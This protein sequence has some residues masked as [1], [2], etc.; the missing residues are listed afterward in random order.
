MGWREMSS[1]SDLRS[2]I[3]NPIFYFPATAACRCGECPLAGSVSSHQKLER[4]FSAFCS[5]G[6]GVCPC[7]AARAGASG[8]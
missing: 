5:A 8:P 4:R 7:T 2:P 1:I 6:P 3:S